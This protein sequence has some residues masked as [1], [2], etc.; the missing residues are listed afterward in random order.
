MNI[1]VCV[2]QVEE[3]YARTGKDPDRHFLDPADRIFR[4]NPYDEAAMQLAVKV[5]AGIENARIVILTIG[6]S[7]SEKELSRIMAMGGDLLYSIELNGADAD[8]AEPDPWCKAQVLARAVQM[9]K[10]DL[11]LCGRASIDRQNGL[12]APYLARLLER[13]FVSSIVNL[14]VAEDGTSAKMTK[15]AG[16]GIREVIECRLPAVF[17]VD[18][19]SGPVLMPSYVAKQQ[20]RKKS[21]TRMVFDVRTFEEKTR[22]IR[23]S[24]PRPRTKPVPAPDS[25]LNGFMRVRQLLTGSRIAKK[26][27]IVSGAPEEQVEEI[28]RFLQANGL[29]PAAAPSDP[30]EQ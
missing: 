23:V 6:S 1:C 14:F 28:I 22:C 26:G 25:S 19:S 11:V 3:T 8:G 17:S 30:A 16:K 7:G 5:A 21:V 2:K 13:P 20:A 29:G 15:N 4:V 12:V 27:K 10:S 18:I 24:A 9:V